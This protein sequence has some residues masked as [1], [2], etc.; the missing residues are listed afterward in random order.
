ME[1]PEEGGAEPCHRDHDRECDRRE[2]G[3]RGGEHR[4]QSGERPTDR[5]GEGGE[6]IGRP[7]E[8]LH[9]ALVLGAGIDGEPDAGVPGPGPERDGDGQGDGE[10]VDPL[11]LDADAA[12]VEHV[13]GQVG[14]D[15]SV[16]RPVALLHHRLEEP[17]EPDCGDDPDDGCRSLQ[18][19]Q[20]ED[21]E[22]QR[23]GCRRDHR[24]HD[25]RKRGPPPVRL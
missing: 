17:E 5:P 18:G 22:R 4:G 14:V 25:R 12:P 2:A 20:H 7:A 24:D 11:F 8:G 21:L 23:H 1:P 13:I 19:A 15:G 9:R 6:A 3:E 10:D 16:G